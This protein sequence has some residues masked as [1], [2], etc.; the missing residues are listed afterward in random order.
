MKITR[1]TDWWILTK[2]Y[3]FNRIGGC[4]EEDAKTIAEN[5]EREQAMRVM[6]LE[7]EDLYRIK[8]QVENAIV[9]QQEAESE[10]G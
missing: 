4:S 7:A 5:I 9:S 1:L 6:L 8:S 10:E 3:G 2:E